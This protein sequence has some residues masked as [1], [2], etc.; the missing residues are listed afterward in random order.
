MD[1]IN[2]QWLRALEEGWSS[3]ARPSIVMGEQGWAR[4][5]RG[6]R[7]VPEINISYHTA[8]QVSKNMPQHSYVILP[9]RHDLGKYL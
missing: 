3:I 8:L 7:E 5:A 2:L 4:G 9:R 1:T 6:N